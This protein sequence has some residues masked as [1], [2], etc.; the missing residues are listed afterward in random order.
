MHVFR[1]ADA[2]ADGEGHETMGGGA[3][4]HVDHRGASMGAGGDVK[5]D[6]FVRALIV[7][8]DG[9]FHGIADVA[10]A[11]FLGATK[12]DTPGDLSGVNIKTGN[13]AFGQHEF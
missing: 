7:V 11:T 3:L 12:L 9:E 6:H 10:Q 8:A 2:A 4:D 5:K 13:N 1:G